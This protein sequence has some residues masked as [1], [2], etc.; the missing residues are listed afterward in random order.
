MNKRF[1]AGAALAV[2]LAAAFW[3]VTSAPLRGP[4]GPW[5]FG[6][7]GMGPGMMLDR[8][9]WMGPGTIGGC[10]PGMMA[11]GWRAPPANVNLSASDVRSYLERWVA[12]GGNPRIK[13]ADVTETDADRITADIVTAGENALV[14]RFAVDRH[15]GFFQ[16]EAR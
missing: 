12:I 10:G 9:G 11:W 13:V 2:V 16:R 3:H 8:T 14:D 6:P 1:L 15:T 4:A 7:F 5:G